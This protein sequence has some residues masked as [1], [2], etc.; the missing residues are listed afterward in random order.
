MAPHCP[1]MVGVLGS[2]VWFGSA[3]HSSSLPISFQSL[4]VYLPILFFMPSLSTFPFPFP[5]CLPSFCVRPIRLF[6]SS[7][8]P[9]IARLISPESF[10]KFVSYMDR[11]SFD[12]KILFGIPPVIFSPT[13]AS[14]FPVIR[15]GSA[16]LGCAFCLVFVISSEYSLYKF[17]IISPNPSCSGRSSIIFCSVTALHAS[18]LCF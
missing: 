15:L 12:V 9:P 7:T 8:T 11:P 5:S 10:L 13:N 4:L 6:P 18:H 3:G 16:L 14:T 17:S 1:F 2:S